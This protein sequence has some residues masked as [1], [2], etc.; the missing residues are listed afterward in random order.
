[1]RS[2]ILAALGY[3]QRDGLSLANDIGIYGQ[4]D[5]TVWSGGERAY[6]G[7]VDEHT[8]ITVVLWAE[9]NAHGGDFAAVG[10]HAI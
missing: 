10:L 6:L 7:V 1:M 4:F 8:G 9:G 5:D 2:D 3:L